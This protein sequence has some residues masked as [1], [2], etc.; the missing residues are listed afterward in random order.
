MRGTKAAMRWNRAS[1]FAVSLLLSASVVSAVPASAQDTASVMRLR[2]LRVVVPRPSTTTGG[3]SAVEIATDSLSVV[4]APTA[5]EFLRR[6]PFIQMRA[7]SRGEVQPDMRGANDR[8]IAVLVD[9]VP[10]TLGWDHRTDM[11]IIPLSAV[12][13]VTLLRGL[14]SMLHGPNVLG[15][16]I[17]FNVARGPSAQ[18]AAPRFSGAFSFDHEGGTSIGATSGTSFARDYANWFLTVG[19]GHRDSPGVSLPGG[20][21]SDPELRREFLADDDGRRLNSDRRL[22]DGFVSIRYQ[23]AEGG[24][25]SSLVTAADG[26]R[27]VPPETH[28]ADPRLWR[29][30]NQSR[31][32]VAMAGGTGE[33]RTSLGQGDLEA[34]FG[35]DRSSTEIDEY[36]SP[37]YRLVADGETGVT[38]TLTG[39]VLGDHRFSAGPEIRS[40]F[41]IANVSHDEAFRDGQTFNYQQRLW[42]LGTEIDVGSGNSS[43]ARSGSAMWSVGASLDGSD[44]PQS[45]DKPALSAMWDW[46]VRTGVTVLGSGGNVLYHAGLSRRTRFPSLRELYSGALGRFEPNPDLRPES[47]KAGEVGVT[48]SAGDARLQLVGFHHRLGDGIVRTRTETPEGAR[49]KRVNR[50]DIRSTGL[51]LLAAGNRGRLNFGGDLTLK[52]V[53]ILD[54]SLGDEEQR[55]EYEPAL[56]GTLNLGVL[57]PRDFNVTGFLRYRGVQYCENVEFA[58]LDRMDSSATLDVEAG[59]V[60]PIG[61]GGGGRRLSANVGIANLTD[62]TVLDQC[63]LPQPG[64]TLRIQFNIR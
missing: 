45:G 27:G 2:G 12:R 34:S 19:A 18:A 32:V 11:S 29:Y 7:N 23:A 13:T 47:L 39:R 40:A 14:S 49:L 55:A 15:G 22:S 41:T 51:E 36:A 38:T 46:G 62:S 33:W 3:T 53:R 9:G 8:Q 43:G 57:A 56:S 30:P 4:A 44:T 58:G 10:L 42:S 63:G 28:V 61:A 35:L 37:G 17:E 52:R 21:R 64:R 16:A 54:S 50:D 48:I 59:R 24:W 25:F 20:A 5:E 1:G 26:H 6:M 31:I 60:F